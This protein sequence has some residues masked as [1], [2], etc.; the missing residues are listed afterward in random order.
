MAKSD[1]MPNDDEGK[2]RLFVRFRDGITPYLGVLGLAADDAQIVA[3]A[4]DATR[5]RALL[6][7][8][9]T[10]QKA[11]KAWTAQ[12]D[13]ELDGSGIVPAELVLPTMSPDFPPPVAPGIVSR[14]RKLVK[15][16]KT[17]DGYNEPM[18]QG[19]GIEGR[20]SFKPDLAAIAPELDAQLVG[21]RVEVKWEYQGL[22]DWVDL[23]EIQVDRGDGRGYVLL[24]FD[25]IPG[26]V[27]TAPLPAVATV[28]KYRAIFRK[29]ETRV[30]QWSKEVRINVG[31]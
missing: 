7:F 9:T 12:K 20:Q 30:G 31:G 10:M 28:W 5:F 25:S 8:A 13:R 24:T 18:G 16:I 27:D 22:S 29:S 23:L 1:Y 19:L 15:W 14:F 26:Y 2:A 17:L 4:A 3:Q 6:D 21:S 11:A